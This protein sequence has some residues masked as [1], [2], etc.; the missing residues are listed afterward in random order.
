MKRIFVVLFCLIVTQALGIKMLHPGDIVKGQKIEVTYFC[1][2]EEEQKGFLA[3]VQMAEK[4]K[5]IQV[6][7]E[8]EIKALRESLVMKDALIRKCEEQ[9]T[10]LTEQ[11]KSA[12]T[13]EKEAA[14]QIEK[15]DGV[16][17]GNRGRVRR[18]FVGGLLGGIG[19]LL[20]GKAIVT[21][22]K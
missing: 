2:T 9:V 5:E 3:L 12:Q 7:Q 16:I 14:V 20:G 11:F 19:V 17:R 6:S 18:S 4:I 10:F 8:N 15:R 21:S 22:G 13:R 1:Y